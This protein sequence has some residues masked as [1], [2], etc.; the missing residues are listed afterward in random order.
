MASRLLGLSMRRMGGAA[1]RS[2]TFPPAV[3]T[4][5][6]PPGGTWSWS[7]PEIMGPSRRTFA[8]RKHKKLIKM[9][10]GY[11]GRA[12]SC[13]TVALQRVNKALTYAYRD[14]KVKKRDFR[15]TWIERLNAASRQHGMG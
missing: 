10:K 15:K 13:Y 4:A 2:R 6:S 9:A 14:R 11:R 1:I 3:L 7:L 12:N 8:T 5:S